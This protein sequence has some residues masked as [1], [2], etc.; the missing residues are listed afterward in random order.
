LEF[1]FYYL[2]FRN[3]LVFRYSDFGFFGYFDIRISYLLDHLEL[4]SQ[5]CC[6]A[7]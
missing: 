4:I 3:C 2:G 7:S 1:G 6:V 5:R